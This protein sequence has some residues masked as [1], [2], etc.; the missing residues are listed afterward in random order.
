ML[1]QM[2]NL[3]ELAHEA[4]RVNDVTTAILLRRATKRILAGALPNIASKNKE[5]MTV[6]E[7]W[8][9]QNEGKLPAIKAVRERQNCG[10]AE[11]K[12]LVEATFAQ[13]GLFF[14]QY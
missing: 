9:G 1:H 3:V 5:A 6:K 13:R 7:I 4:V 14:H 11:A 10:L 12:N 8:I 2:E